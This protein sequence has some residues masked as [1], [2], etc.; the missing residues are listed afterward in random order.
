MHTFFPDLCAGFWIQ[1]H[2]CI[3]VLWCVRININIDTDTHTHTTHTRACTHTHT[4]AH[5]RTYKYMCIS[6]IYT[7]IHTRTYA[8]TY[9]YT[10]MY[11]YVYIYDTYESKLNL[12]NVPKSHFQIHL[13]VPKS[14]RVDGSVSGAESVFHTTKLENARGRIVNTHVLRKISRDK[15]FGSNRF[16]KMQNGLEIFEKDSAAYNV[17]QVWWLPVV[18]GVRVCVCVCIRERQRARACVREREGEWGRQR[19]RNSN[20]IWVKYHGYTEEMSQY[21]YDRDE[22]WMCI[23]MNTYTYRCVC[24]CMCVCVWVC[25]HL[26][27]CWCVYVYTCIH[28]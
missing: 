13:Q 17:C 7:W 12:I 9:T 26:C 28:L 10:C 11:M 18:P 1:K 5:T 3:Y 15:G 22:R 23:Q 16:D 27:E 19:E 2:I 20:S 25:V 6:C 8:Y 14:K 21:V 4:H 24:V